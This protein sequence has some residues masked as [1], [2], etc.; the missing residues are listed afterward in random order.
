MRIVTLWSEILFR[1]FICKDKTNNS[2]M[3]YRQSIFHIFWFSEN[4]CGGT[5]LCIPNACLLSPL[6]TEA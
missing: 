5:N 3:Q 2:D 6:I 4:I 1:K